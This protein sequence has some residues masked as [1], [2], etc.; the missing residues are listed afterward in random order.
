MEYLSAIL[1][2]WSAFS[3]ETWDLYSMASFMVDQFS[4]TK[5]EHEAHRNGRLGTPG[6]SPLD[7]TVYRITIKKSFQNF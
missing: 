6:M 5:W 3:Y 2:Y 4:R 1:A 7:K